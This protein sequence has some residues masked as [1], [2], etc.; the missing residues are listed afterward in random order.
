MIEKKVVVK[1]ETGIHARPAG[2]I[3]RE[4]SKF[5]SNLTLIKDDKEYNA[6]SIMS[7]MTMA[8]ACGQ[9]IT[10]RADGEDEEEALARI[11]EIIMSGLE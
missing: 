3:V 9:E 7:L 2:L 10:V 8:A 5:K 1:N 11:S 4:A 6:K